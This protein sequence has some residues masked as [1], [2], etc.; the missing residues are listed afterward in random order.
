MI[1]VM[2]YESLFSELKD[3]SILYDYGKRDVYYNGLN[4][5]LRRKASFRMYVINFAAGPLSL[6]TIIH[7][8]CLVIL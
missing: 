4:F 7:L 3:L 2:S 5:I 6:T 8:T 1:K